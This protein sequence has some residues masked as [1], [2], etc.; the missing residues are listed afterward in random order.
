M[1]LPY[2]ALPLLALSLMTPGVVGAQAPAP[3]PPAA[4]PSA[5][6]AASVAPPAAPSPTAPPPAP[7]AAATTPA[8][9][10]AP[11]TAAT[12]ALASPPSAPAGCLVSGFRSVGLQTHDIAQRE[13]RALAWLRA[14]GERCT[15]EQMATIGSNL[16]IWLGRAESVRISTIVEGLLHLAVNPDERNREQ[17]RRALGIPPPP[18][19]P[20]PAP[21]VVAVAKAPPPEGPRPQ[22]QTRITNQQ[23]RTIAAHYA[24]W[25]GNESCPGTLVP[26]E[27][28]CESHPEYVRAWTYGQALPNT[29]QTQT[30]PKALLDS[31]G[32]AKTGLEWTLLDND[33]LLVEIR[34]RKI[35]DGVLDLGRPTVKVPAP[36]VEAEAAPKRPLQ[37]PPRV[38]RDA[39]VQT[40]K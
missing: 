14:Q 10:E 25:P 1:R 35:I 22:L 4:A 40:P 19:P 31:L 8:A 26:F 20:K 23:R 12:P 3:A 5:P 32:A 39:P 38:L 9:L 27:K 29:A 36:P 7:A 6:A 33:V 37:T 2:F 34:S 15:A 16:G 24:K 13:Q 30:P 21:P 11:P 18:P 17:V 28:R